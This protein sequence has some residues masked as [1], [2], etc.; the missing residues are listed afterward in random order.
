MKVL[1]V[2]DDEGQKDLIKQALAQSDCSGGLAT[3]ERQLHE[4]LALPKHLVEGKEETT[5]SATKKAWREASKRR[6]RLL[7]VKYGG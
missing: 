5:A 2:S 7:K 4:G 6:E 3:F 1:I